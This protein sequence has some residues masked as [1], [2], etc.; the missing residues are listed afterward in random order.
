MANITILFCAKM[1]ESCTCLGSLGNAATNV[2]SILFAVDMPKELGQVQA[3]RI[4]AYSQ[5]N[6][7]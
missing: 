1:I 3:T 6:L 5:I 7:I 2:G 4:F